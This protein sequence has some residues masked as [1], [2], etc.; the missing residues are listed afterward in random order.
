MTEGAAEVKTGRRRSSS[1]AAAS[2]SQTP[3][4][5]GEFVRPECG[6]T[7]SR[8]Q[9]LGA[10]RSRTHGVPGGKRA[11]ASAGAKSRAAKAGARGRGGAAGGRSSGARTRSSQGE[12]GQVDRDQL[13]AVVFPNGVPAKVS[14]IE[15]LAPWLAEGERLSRMR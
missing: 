7:F 6:K 5:G 12:G 14:V 11:R 2:S 1:G 10:H 3:P 4:T 15:A 8:A 13:L 9:A